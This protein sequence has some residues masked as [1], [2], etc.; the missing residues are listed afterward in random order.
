MH[1]AINCIAD[2][3]DIGACCRVFGCGH[4]WEETH[5]NYITDETPFNIKHELEDFGLF[6]CECANLNTEGMCKDYENRPDTCS[7]FQPATD[8]LCLLFVGPPQ[9]NSLIIAHPEIASQRFA[10]P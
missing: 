4:T 8:P 10:K 5:R 1:T 2:C 6:I 3:P 9:K 7:T